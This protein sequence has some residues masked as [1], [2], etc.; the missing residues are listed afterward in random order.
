MGIR[1]G[2]RRHPQHAG[3][4]LYTSANTIGSLNPYDEQP[5]HFTLP[6]RQV[7]HVLAQH[8]AR[9][10]DSKQDSDNLWRSI[11]AR[12]TIGQAQGLLMERYELAAD[13]AFAVLC[14]YSENHHMRL[15]DVAL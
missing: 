15:H 5:Q 2:P 1:G 8:S 9:T 14:R 7:A 12:Q 4:R 10:L 11:D 13:H 3:H 6:D